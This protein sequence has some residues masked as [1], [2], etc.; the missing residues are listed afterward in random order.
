MSFKS[1]AAM[2]RVKDPKKTLVV[3]QRLLLLQDAFE[4]TR[5]GASARMAECLGITLHRWY[6]VPQE[7]RK[8]PIARRDV[9]ET[10]LGFG[11]MILL[12]Q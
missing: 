5:R 8:S 1:A 11:S 6:N 3:A 7:P 12:G 2:E 9:L 4:G 10:R